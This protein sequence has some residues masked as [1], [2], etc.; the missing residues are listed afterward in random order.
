M[1]KKRRAPAIRKE[2]ITAAPVKDVETTRQWVI[3][4]ILGLTF[5]AFS[6]TLFHGFAYDDQT[7]ILE[8]KFIHSFSNIPT[9]F[10]TEVWFWRVLQ[11]K[12]PNKETGPTTPYY[13]PM[14][15][16]YLMIGWA[17][18][19]DWSLGWHFLNVLM[20]LS[21]VFFVFKILEKVSGDL[22]V[23]AFGALLF[24]LHPLRTESVAW[25]SGVTDLFLAFFLLPSFYLYMVHREKG[26]PRYLLGS[27]GLFLLAAF[28]K[29][30]AVCLP[31]F[32]AA[33]EI[34]IINRDKPL[35]ERGRAAA[36]FAALFI[37]VP[38]VYFG[39]RY[40]ALGFVLSDVGYTSYPFHEV[41]L[42]IPLVIFKYIGLLLFPFNLTLFHETQLVRGPLS[43]RFILPLIGLA[44][45][46]AGL[47]PFRRSLV[48]RFGVL[49]FFIH[50]LP[51][52]NLSAFA[53]EFMVQERYVYIPSVGFSLLVAMVLA[54][55]PVEQWLPFRSRRAGQLATVAV[56]CLLLMGKTVFQNRVWADDMTLWNYGVEAAPE[57]TMPHF[58]LAHKYI[59]LNRQDKVVE[60]LEE[61][62][63]IDQR[64]IIVITNLA[65]SHLLMY[66]QTKERAHVDRAIALC[67][68]GLALND[69]V[70]P[71]WDTFGRAY[72]LD[73]NLRSYD[74]AH[75]YFDRGL[76]IQ[77]QNAMLNFHKGAAYAV[78]QKVEAA[79]PYLERARQLEP[80]LPDTYK[81]LAYVYRSRGRI[82]E[83]IDNFNQYLRLQPDAIDAPRVRQDLQ[84]LQAQ[85]QSATPEG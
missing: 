53:I 5:L 60:S 40:K 39:M 36:G 82:Q 64:N 79:L 4:L 33:Y 73:T 80:G 42:T 63:K 45:I 28:S 20:H 44:G 43:L 24:A 46:A 6:N 26:D 74:R 78:E 29:E 3:A 47:W 48:A 12:D 77:P 65:T 71:L 8:N 84:Q 49:W 25:I 13:R 30:P 27:L 75:Y 7:Q 67:E 85:L 62:M 18:F 15:T 57:Q 51:V 11:D 32:I 61:Y 16:V 19:Q 58:V 1:G 52:L 83:A 14:F 35:R 66:D 21:S 31:I 54:K 38:F 76:K 56:I 59:N 69:Q 10:T 70:A 41:V 81:M 37:T 50:L 9:A 17:L 22:R 55:L 72:L 23:A 34:W 68:K 2:P